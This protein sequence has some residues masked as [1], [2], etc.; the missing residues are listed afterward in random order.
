ML[1]GDAQGKLKGARFLGYARNNNMSPAPILPAG[2]PRSL[3]IAKGANPFFPRSLNSF[4][5]STRMNIRA[6]VMVGEVPNG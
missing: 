6:N 1:A 4:A 5:I 3:R 2:I